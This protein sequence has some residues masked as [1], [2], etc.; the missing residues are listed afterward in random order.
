MIKDWKSQSLVQTLLN[1]NERCKLFKQTVNSV[2]ASMLNERV[3]DQP[4]VYLHFSYQIVRLT[5]SQC[6]GEEAFSSDRCSSIID[7]E[8]RDINNALL[9][10][11]STQQDVS[12]VMQLRDQQAQA[13]IDLVDQVKVLFLA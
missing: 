8:T 11:L 2:P 9:R 13:F 1:R 3:R 5:Q 7:E 6:N 4:I 10:C 12:E